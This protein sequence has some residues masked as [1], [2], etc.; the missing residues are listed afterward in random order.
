MQTTGGDGV[1]IL[2][3]I[4]YIT[5]AQCTVISPCNFNQYVVSHRLVIGNSSGHHSAFGPDGSM[6]TASY[7]N[8]ANY[9]ADQNAVATN[10]ASTM[11]LNSRKCAFVSETYFPSPNYDMPGFQTGT[12]VYA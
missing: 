10:V 5:A 2:S 11:T 1:V 12:G 9:M 6:I 8:V 7:G 3:K 4:T